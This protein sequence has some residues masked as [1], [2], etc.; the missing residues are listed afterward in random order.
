MG[1][2]E[3]RLG[4]LFSFRVTAWFWPSLTNPAEKGKE[5]HQ[6]LRS[7]SPLLVEEELVVLV[8]PRVSGI[9]VTRGRRAHQGGVS[10]APHDP[11]ALTADKRSGKAAPHSGEKRVVTQQ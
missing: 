1:K 6:Q 3:L 8:N 11:G 9:A 4:V 2:V 10:Q 7:H 5:G